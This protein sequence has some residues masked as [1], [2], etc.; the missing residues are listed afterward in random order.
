MLGLQQKQLH[1]MTDKEI[2]Q[3]VQITAPFFQQISKDDFMVDLF[4]TEEWLAHFP[5]HTIDV[6]SNVGG[7]IPQEDPVLQGALKGKAQVGRPPFEVYQVNFLG[8]TLPIRNGKNKVI[9]VLG[10]GYNID[11]IIEIEKK[12]ELTEQVLAKVRSY[13]SEIGS[14]SDSL[15]KSNESLEEQTVEVNESIKNIDGVLQII[16]KVSSQTN[17]LGLNAS[18]EAA[19]A[20]EHGL[21]FSVVA[22]EVRKLAKETV[23]ASEQIRSYVRAIKISTDHLI[24]SFENVDRSVDK[25]AELVDNFSEVSEELDQLNKDMNNAVRS[26]LDVS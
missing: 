18:I 22:N 21:G 26:M 13:I 14:S 6:P 2:L 17:I 9:G 12:L 11:N 10:V 25:N 3:A 5:G 15:E 8:K 19:R 20:G 1:S 16:D 24:K 23:K 7:P 4:S